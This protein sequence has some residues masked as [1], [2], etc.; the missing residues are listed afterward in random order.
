MRRLLTASVLGLVLAATPAFAADDQTTTLAPALAAAATALAPA[1]ALLTAQPRTPA[2]RRPALLPALYA[3]TALLQGYDA[4]ST[5]TVLQRGGVEANPLMRGLTARPAMFIGLKAGVATLSIVAAE[6]MWKRG[7][8]LG[9]VA[10]MVASNGFMAYVAAHN[11]RV[12][13]QQGR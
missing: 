2:P 7:N 4:Y 5:L 11:A 6:R 9:A 12:L 13:A 1:P 10:A 8:R 3:G